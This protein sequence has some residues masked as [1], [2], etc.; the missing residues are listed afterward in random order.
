MG[1][2]RFHLLLVGPLLALVLATGCGGSSNSSSSGSSGS[3]TVSDQ[4]RAE[5]AAAAKQAANTVVKAT[6]DKN[7]RGSKRYLSVCL[8]KGDPD[9]GDLPPN[10][11]KCH[12]EA[13]YNTYKSTPGGY[14]WSEDWNVPIQNGKPG[15]PVINGDYRIRNFLREDNRKN[16]VGRHVPRE[17]LPQSAGGILPG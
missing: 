6:P 12:I 5:A 1:I 7:I 2:E 10:I 9:A 4:T 17:C 16:C 13:F 8:A 14:I 15:T 11:V 3:S